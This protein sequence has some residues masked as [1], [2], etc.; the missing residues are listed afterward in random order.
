MSTKNKKDWEAAI[1]HLVVN[2]WDKRYIVIGFD[3]DAICS[4][5]FLQHLY[6]QAQIIAAYDTNAVFQLM[7][8]EKE[9]FRRALIT[10][11]WV[12]QDVLNN[13]LC[14]G[15]HATTSE[16]TQPIPDKNSN[17]FNPNEFFDQPFS[18]SFEKNIPRMPKGYPPEGLPRSKCPYSTFIL[19]LHAF[20]E[21]WTRNEMFDALIRHCD[22]VAS[23]IRNYGSNC[24]AWQRLLFEGT[25]SQINQIMLETF[26]VYKPPRLQTECVCIFH[27]NADESLRKKRK[28]FDQ[29]I[30]LMQSI[31]DIAG[32]FHDTFSR[33]NNKTDATN[34]FQAR[35]DAMVQFTTKKRTWEQMIQASNN[36]NPLPLPQ[37]DDAELTRKMLPT[38]CGGGYQGV[39][40]RK[41]AADQT[42][43][44][45]TFNELY[46]EIAQGA[47]QFATPQI[48]NTL[49][50]FLINTAQLAD[51]F[52]EKRPNRQ[53]TTW[54]RIRG[55]SKSWSLY[56]FIVEKNIFSY[57]ILSR[58]CLRYTVKRGTGIF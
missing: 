55:Q 18:M 39:K 26:D 45:A 7:N 30:E 24:E 19:L 12:D 17:S 41:F 46:S 35:D 33:V 14:I 40:L 8:M 9:E 27:A 44:L 56:E 32:R 50:Y 2:V 43:F 42:E 48:F 20:D 31:K 1:R 37:H 23:N 25:N 10:A 22:S 4:G 54:V 53:E 57:A 34:D 49:K 16:C 21:K 5:L 52:F 36:N 6:P 13:L 29:Q 3:I 38:V 15:Q 47:F 28:V 11:L 51:I 58:S